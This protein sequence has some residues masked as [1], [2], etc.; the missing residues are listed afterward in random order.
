M[1]CNMERLFFGT[2]MLAGTDL[3]FSYELQNHRYALVAMC[4]NVWVFGQQL[5]DPGDFDTIIHTACS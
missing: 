3:W 5:W 4:R 1:H 2:G